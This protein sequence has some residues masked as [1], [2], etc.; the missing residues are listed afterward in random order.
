MEQG[1]RRHEQV[2]VRA[3]RPDH[4][5][6]RHFG[7]RRQRVEPEVERRLPVVQRRGDDRG[8]EQPEER[9]GEQT[10][11]AARVEG[12]QRD[13]ARRRVLREQAGR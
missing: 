6:V 2:G 10:T 9:R 11:G 3:P 12:L 13:P 1:R 7:D 5:P 8:E 4:P